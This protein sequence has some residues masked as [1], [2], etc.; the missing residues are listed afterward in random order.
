MFLLKSCWQYF[1]SAWQVLEVQNLSKPSG[2]VLR[3]RTFCICLFALVLNMEKASVYNIIFILN[4]IQ[5]ANEQGK[6]KVKLSNV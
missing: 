3:G 6:H 1:L 2:S 5:I 4:N